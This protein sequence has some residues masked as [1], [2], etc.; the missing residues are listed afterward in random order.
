VSYGS[1]RA[2]KTSSESPDSVLNNAPIATESSPIN[3]LKSTITAGVPAWSLPIRS[4]ILFIN[5]LY[6][7]E[8]SVDFYKLLFI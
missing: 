4:M 6:F 1:I 2:V 3:Q 8:F 5:S 7:S